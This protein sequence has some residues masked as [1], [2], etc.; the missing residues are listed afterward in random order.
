MLMASLQPVA[1]YRSADR[2]LRRFELRACLLDL[3]LPG[4]ELPFRHAQRRSGRQLARRG[5]LPL[6]VRLRVALVG[7]YSLVAQRAVTLG[8]RARKLRIGLCA[9]E[10]R[11]ILRDRR[12][13]LQHLVAGRGEIRL[14]RIDCRHLLRQRVLVVAHVDAQ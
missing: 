11:A 1:G 10:L 4:G 9:G 2:G 13:L 12:P 7:L 14:A 3:A 6:V 8:L 5:L